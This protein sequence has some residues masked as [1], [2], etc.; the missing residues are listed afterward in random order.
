[1]GVF[2][3]VH[4]GLMLQAFKKFWHLMKQYII[5]MSS[6]M[7]IVMLIYLYDGEYTMLC[8]GQQFQHLKSQ[9]NMTDVHWVCNIW[10]VYN[11]WWSFALISSGFHHAWY[12]SLRILQIT[13]IRCDAQRSD[14]TSQT[15]TYYLFREVSCI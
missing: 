11:I 12:Y 5:F 7:W 9:S 1:M 13:C 15:H 14:T 2:C 10:W 6:W 4:F 3:Y 8:L